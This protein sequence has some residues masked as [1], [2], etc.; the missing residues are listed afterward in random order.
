MTEVRA[1]KPLGLSP[2]FGFGDRLGL[3]TLGHLDAIRAYGGR[4]LPIFA[5]QSIREMNRTR[6]SPSDVLRDTVAA[7]RAASYGGEWG[8]DAN[9]LKTQEDVNATAGA[10][11]VFFTIDPSEHV[12]PRADSY[13]SATLDRQ[14]REIYNDVNWADEYFGRTV[15]IDDTLVIHFDAVSVRRTAVKYGRAISHA[16]KLAAH[17][18]RVM[19]KR[20]A[21]YEIELS[22]DETPQPTTPSEHFI[23]ADQCLR[24]KMKLVSLAP[25]YVGHFEKG[26]DYKGDLQ[27]FALSLADHAAIAR[28]LGPYKLSLH[29]GSD[30]LTIYETL[31]RVTGGMFHVKTAGTSYLEG[32]RVASRHHR[33]L[34]RR[35]V[36]CSR[37]QFERDRASYPISAR[38]EKV[39]PP[40]AIADDAK[41]E[42]LYLDEDDGRQILHV[43]FGSVLTDT[44]LGPSLRDVLVAHPET[45]REV[46]ARH[47]GKHLKALSKGL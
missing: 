43:T 3:A 20:A 45:H 4:I 18:D 44:G 31:A 28:H 42:R 13:D 27:K 37:S 1:P 15:Q 25:R 30:K 16:I 33:K 39:P 34:F 36:D 22:I 41:L 5:Q 6:R 26:I 46:L 10:G 23:I 12:D 38:L 19:G 7:L 21:D 35:I 2:T 9:H 14:F 17:I 47:F 29:S 11:F 40:A 8:A 32:L 24:S